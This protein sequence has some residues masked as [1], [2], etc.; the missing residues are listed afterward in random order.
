MHTKYSRS[1]HRTP[2]RWTPR[3]GSSARQKHHNTRKRHIPTTESKIYGWELCDIYRWYASKSITY[4]NNGSEYDDDI[5]H[6]ET[7][8]TRIK[9]IV[10]NI[11]T[12]ASIN[13]TEQTLLDRSRPFTKQ[14]EIH[15]LERYIIQLT[16]SIQLPKV[17]YNRF[18]RLTKSYTNTKPPFQRYTLDKARK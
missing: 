3:L 5:W 4:L 12:T 15:S 9:T 14:S 2:R 17:T 6:V 8:I 13:I 1:R 10:T 11:H 18:R 7:H 16:I